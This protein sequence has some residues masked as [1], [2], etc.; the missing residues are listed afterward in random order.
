MAVPIRIG[1]HTKEPARI[2]ELKKLKT[3]NIIEIA[4]VRY[5]RCKKCGMLIA[6]DDNFVNEGLKSCPVCLKTA[7]FS[8]NTITECKIIK[9]NHERTIEICD[10]ELIRTFGEANLVR[11]QGRHCWIYRTE[12]TSIPIVIS[13]VSSYNQ[14]INNRADLCWLCI[15]VDW[16]A[17]KDKLNSYNEL[18]FIRIED[19]IDH[20]V[21]LLERLNLIAYNFKTNT[22]LDLESRFDKF[23][24]PISGTDFESDFVNTFWKAIQE[25]TSELERYLTFLSSQRNAITNS[26][27]VFMGF[28]GNADFAVL[29]LKKYLQECLKPDKIGEAKRYHCDNFHSTEFSWEDFSVALAHAD[30]ADALFILSTNN[31]APS[32][33]RR[34]I[35]KYQNLGYFKY[36]IIDK[37]IILLLLKVLSLEDLVSK[38]L[39]PIERT[40]RKRAKRKDQAQ[41]KQSA[42]KKIPP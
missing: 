32:V 30:G 8:T 21:N 14:F 26:K 33:W 17:T 41:P 22:T 4:E 29:D 6:I 18:N 16:E 39:I 15:V 31:I 34:V 38:P 12:N 1:F 35:E 13:D 37:D 25:K 7:V 19:I 24:E 23:I 11:D 2:E 3:L 42:R 9:L 20:K 10:A 28:A 40:I 27:V 36:V 5:Q